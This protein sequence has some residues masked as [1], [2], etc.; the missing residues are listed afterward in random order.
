MKT[1][2]LFLVSMLMTASV[3]ADQVQIKFAE[4]HHLGNT[5]NISVT[6][7]HKDSGWNHYANAW[8]IVDGKNKLIRKR[9]LLHPH[10]NEQPF[11]RSLY[12]VKIPGNTKVI[13]IEAMDSIHGVSPD[14]LRI[15][16]SRTSGKRYKINK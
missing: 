4:L 5:W 8:Q 6:L 7:K 14:R 15:D 16:L 10:V 1:K 12:S 9:V 11:T 3:Q 2:L 13:F